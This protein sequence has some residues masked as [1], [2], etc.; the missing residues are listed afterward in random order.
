MV[1]FY[2]SILGF[3]WRLSLGSEL[4]LTF[5]SMLQHLLRGQFDVDPQVVGDE[6]FLRNGHVYAYW[7]PWC[8]LLRL[9]LWVVRRL[10][11]DM[12]A[13][14]C[15]LAV[16]IAGMAKVRAVLLVRRHGAQNPIAAWA[17]GLMLVYSLLAGGEIGYL[18][19]SLYQ[20][21]VLWAFAFAEVFV[22]WAVKGL[23]LGRF[24]SATLCSMALVT[25]LAILT[26]VS[27]GIGL[28]VAMVLLL[29]VLA[30]Q[31]GKASSAGSRLSLRHLAHACINRR[32]LFPVAILAVLLAITGIVNYFRWGSAI[33]FADYRIYLSNDPLRIARDQVYGLFNLNRIP[34][35]LVYYFLPVWVLHGNNG[36]LLFQQA[37][38]RL[39]DG[40]EVPPSSFFLTDLLPLCFILLLAIA[41]W[42]RRPGGLPRL[43]QWAAAIAVGLFGPC[44]LMLTAVYL[45]YRYRMEFYPEIDFLAF[46]GLYLTLTDE[47]LLRTFARWRR[48]MTTALAVSIVTSFVALLL[49]DLGGSGPLYDPADIPSSGIIPEGIVRLYWQGAASL[50][51]RGMA[52]LHAHYRWL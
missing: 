4:N 51:L 17:A 41:L 18:H 29:A 34:F 8:A 1:L 39:F 25:G 14:S 28:L 48:W 31:A 5:N 9:P 11:I 38:I 21:V 33:T 26:R 15:L 49:Y 40:I 6:G 45:A 44:V 16:C 47:A 22:Y 50:F 3:S 36:E 2:G 19:V 12:T 23:V 30:I 27:T 43:G 24:N 10:D 32:I 35:G 46:L 42:K 37:Q 20:E 52:R 13:W 7:G